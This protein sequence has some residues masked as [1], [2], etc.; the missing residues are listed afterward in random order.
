[1][2][3][4]VFSE[5][6]FDYVIRF[7]SVGCT[8]QINI[9]HN[10]EIL[11][12]STIVSNSLVD[13]TSNT[14]NYVFNPDM[15]FKIFKQYT[16]KTLHQLSTIKFPK[17]YKTPDVPLMIEIITVSCYDN[18]NV[19]TK[20]IVVDPVKIS[21]EKRFELKLEQRDKQIKQLF[22]KYDSVMLR[23]NKK[24]D[25]R[26]S[27]IEQ[28]TASYALLEGKTTDLK[29]SFDAFEKDYYLTNGDWYTNAQ[30]DAKLALIY[31]K[32]E[33]DAKYTITGTS[34]TKAESDA[35]YTITG[36]SYTKAES[37][38]KYTITSTSYTKAE[39]DGRYAQ[40]GVAYTKAET[41]AKCA[42]SYSK[43]ESD[44]KYAQIVA[45]YTK[46]ETDAKYAPKA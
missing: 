44:G 9:T 35:K 27:K 43:A 33:S 7:D 18:N 12:W 26:D 40:I 11:S 3:D 45:V 29:A 25:K 41:D 39:T 37:D 2:S 24:L 1:M 10:A 38:A 13:S 19:D 23:L 46:D 15:L 31:T 36:T 4:I 5:D 21:S 20:I 32:A 16:E 8:L 30:I 22:E 34:Y 6:G 14:I 28:L 42:T 17:F